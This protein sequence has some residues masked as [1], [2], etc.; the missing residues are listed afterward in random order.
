[1]FENDYNL[2]VQVFNTFDIFEIEMYI[3]RYVQLL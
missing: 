2:N 3:S 1:M